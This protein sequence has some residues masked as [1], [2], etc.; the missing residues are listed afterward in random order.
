MQIHRGSA[1]TASMKRPMHSSAPKKRFIGPI[2]KSLLENRKN[3]DILLVS[4]AKGKWISCP[5]WGPYG[6]PAW[7]SWSTS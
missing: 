7:L 6:N 4:L 1:S 5:K 3:A 2:S